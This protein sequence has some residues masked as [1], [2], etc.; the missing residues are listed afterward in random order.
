M[1][2]THMSIVRLQGGRDTWVLDA[3]I[4]GDFDNINPEFILKAIGN[5]PG[6]ELIITSDCQGAE[7]G[8]SSRM[9]ASCST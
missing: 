2:S 6:R 7:S 8:L 1:I 9:R 3:D 5:L 4:K